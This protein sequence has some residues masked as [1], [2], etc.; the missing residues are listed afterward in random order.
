MVPWSS[1]FTAQTIWESLLKHR[2]LHLTPKASESTGPEW[3]QGACF[4]NKFPGDAC[5]AGLGTTKN[6]C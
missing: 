1:D 3:G 2:L 5:A 4:S 6:H